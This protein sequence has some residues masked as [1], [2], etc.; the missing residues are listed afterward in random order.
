M[1][2]LV[3]RQAGNDVQKH[4]HRALG[5]IGRVSLF[6]A[7]CDFASVGESPL[8]IFKSGPQVRESSLEYLPPS[9]SLVISPPPCPSRLSPDLHSLLRLFL[10]QKPRS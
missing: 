5:R 8:P 4:R 7:G 2:V 3:K 6:R 1:G 10:P 9:L